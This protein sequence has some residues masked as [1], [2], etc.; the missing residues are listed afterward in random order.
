VTE[1]WHL[2]VAGSNGVT[3]RLASGTPD[4]ITLAFHQMAGIFPSQPLGFRATNWTLSV[5]KPGDELPTPT[6]GNPK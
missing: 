2:E 3:I 6:E 4:V 5:Q 1:T